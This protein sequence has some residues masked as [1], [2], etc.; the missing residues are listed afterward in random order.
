MSVATSKKSSVQ[1]LVFAIVVALACSFALSAAF[2]AAPAYAD[3]ENAP[4]ADDN[5]AAT[6]ADS[7]AAGVAV[8][9]DA[10]VNSGLS[11]AAGPASYP[12]DNGSD[13]IFIGLTPVKTDTEATAPYG[14]LPANATITSSAN[15][16]AVYV[17]ITSK[18]GD[19]VDLAVMVDYV[20][21]NADTYG[22]GDTAVLPMTITSGSTSQR[23][24]DYFMI[25]WYCDGTPFDQGTYYS[26]LQEYLTATG[27]STAGAAKPLPQVDGATIDVARSFVLW[28]GG[29]STGYYDAAGHLRFMG[30][31]ASGASA[32]SN[33]CLFPVGYT[34]Q[35]EASDRYMLDDSNQPRTFVLYFETSGVR[36]ISAQ[37]TYVREIVNGGNK[38][39]IVYA[40]VPVVFYIDVKGANQGT[41][42]V[43]GKDEQ[44]KDVD[45]DSMNYDDGNTPEF[46]GAIFKKYKHL[47][48]YTDDSFGQP[49]DGGS[50]YVMLWEGSVYGKP[51]YGAY[52]SAGTYKVVAEHKTGKYETLVAVFTVEDSEFEGGKAVTR[53]AALLFPGSLGKYKVRF[54]DEDGTTV[55]LSEALY[56]ENTSGSDVAKPATPT[57]AEDTTAYYVFDY[58]QVVEKGLSTVEP[59][60]V[61]DNYTYKAHYKTISKANIASA[62]GVSA[63]GGLFNGTPSDGVASYELTVNPISSTASSVTSNMSIIGS[64]NS[65]LGA[66]EVDI[67]RHNTDG[68]TAKVTTN[69]GAL[70]LE[71]PVSGVA[72]GTAVQ[73]VQIHASTGADDPAETI[74]H[75]GVVSNGKVSVT[76]NDKLSTFIVATNLEPQGAEEGSSGDPATSDPTSETA[77]Q[78][79][80]APAEGDAPA[81]NEDDSAMR[82]MPAAEPELGPDGVLA[83]GPGDD[84]AIEGVKAAPGSG[85]GKLPETG[86]AGHGLLPVALIVLSAA[87]AASAFSVRRR[88]SER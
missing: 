23:A 38:S 20:R 26:D 64:N 83:D 56:D 48:D 10:A 24:S 1:N 61:T 52:A 76:V 60:D 59:L 4:A 8:N 31:K 71:L 62:G 67:T 32:G 39:Q 69:V 74:K 15:G 81:T 44:G 58:W 14:D 9:A 79:S 40:S 35:V 33:G 63:S 11:A 65:V 18:V 82:G 6:P 7:A 36:T 19:A 78:E 17:G 29:P 34:S 86:D 3:G 37:A 16:D 85:E 75:T 70:T 28:G 27:S 22:V 66:F 68:T 45:I 84:I 73:V 55:L 41:F 30:D 51:G 57:K 80:G 21:V 72:D 47:D 54:V 25:N 87:M 88:Q 42:S 49:Y 5:A 43:L 2:G 50:N 46:E 13:D 53:T 77:N 12:G